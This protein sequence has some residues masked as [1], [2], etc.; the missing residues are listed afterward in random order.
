MHVYVGP[1]VQN[2]TNFEYFVK[3]KIIKRDSHIF[4]KAIQ[5]LQIWM[6]Q[7]FQMKYS[8]FSKLYLSQNNKKIVLSNAD[9]ATRA[10]SLS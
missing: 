5:G 8:S 7:Q 9:R 10:N 6:L 3:D 2:F 1:S 4:N